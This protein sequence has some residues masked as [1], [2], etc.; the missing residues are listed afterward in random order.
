MIE[1]I[2]INDNLIYF[3]WGRHP[4]HANMDMRL[5]GGCHV[6]HHSSEAIVVDT[7]GIPRSPCLHARIYPHLLLHPHTPIYWH[8]LIYS[9]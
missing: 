7:M 3:Y 8:I 5:G 2:R 9:D 1:P 4:S 6:I